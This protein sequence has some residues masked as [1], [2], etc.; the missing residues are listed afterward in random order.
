MRSTSD[1]DIAAAVLCTR[2]VSVGMLFAQA[3]QVMREYEAASSE[4]RQHQAAHGRA[5]EP[6]ADGSGTA[7]P[8]AEGTEADTAEALDP[9]RD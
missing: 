9:S 5:E 7:G 6:G 3:R 2:E 8:G 1:P 4:P